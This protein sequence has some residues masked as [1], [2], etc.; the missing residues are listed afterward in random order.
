MNWSAKRRLANTPQIPESRDFATMN[1]SLLSH[2][3]AV[4][5]WFLRRTTVHHIS[6]LWTLVR[7]ELHFILGV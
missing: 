5:C 6:V 7:M 2:P 3:T 1:T 4:S